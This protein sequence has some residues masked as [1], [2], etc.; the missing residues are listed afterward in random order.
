MVPRYS[1]WHPDLKSRTL[2]IQN[3]PRL[4]E[5]NV[6]SQPNACVSREPFSRSQ[7]P[8]IEGVGAHDQ[9]SVVM[10]QS[11]RG[12]YSYVAIIRRFSRYPK[13]KNRWL[14]LNRHCHRTSTEYL[15]TSNSAVTGNLWPLLAVKI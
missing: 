7:R 1:I 9:V 10:Q 11:D 6:A 14:Q 13:E 2:I 5:R 8:T 12:R 4:S 3:A 15:P